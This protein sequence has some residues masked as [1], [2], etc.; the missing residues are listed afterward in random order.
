MSHSFCARRDEDRKGIKVIRS[1]EGADGGEWGG[2]GKDEERGMGR[3]NKEC[4]LG[5][6]G[7]ERGR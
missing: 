4:G 6:D 2:R 7:G 5:L 3:R 1:A